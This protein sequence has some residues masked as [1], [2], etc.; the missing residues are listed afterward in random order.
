VRAEEKQVDGPEIQRAEQ[1]ESLLD[2]EEKE[3]Q[4]GIA[5]ERP[6]DHERDTQLVA[7]M[8]GILE[9]RPIAVRELGLP[10]RETQA[11]EMLQNAVNG[12]H[13]RTDRFTYAEDRRS[14][15]EQALAILQPN[16]TSSHTSIVDSV[17]T[18]VEQLVGQVHDLRIYL[19]NLEDS[20]EDLHEGVR[21]E[22][23]ASPA[24]AGDTA[25]KPKPTDEDGTPT[26]SSLTDGPEAKRSEKKSSL[27]DGPD[28]KRESTKSSLSDGPEATRAD[29]PTDIWVDPD[30]DEPGKP[31]KP[32]WRR[33]LG[34]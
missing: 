13:V 16:L 7:T 19:M 17:R 22:K 29:K 32:W 30:P 15:L 2:R 6:V 5:N 28:A 34:Q 26:K 9:K 4:Q 20:Q 27:S 10:P 1:K 31:K 3:L 18:E 24:G 14:M 21:Q 11:L 33:V 12:R 25:D 23:F 8:K